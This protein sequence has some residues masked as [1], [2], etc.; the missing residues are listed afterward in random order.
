MDQNFQ[1]GMIGSRDILQIVLASSAV[2]VELLQQEPLND[3]GLPTTNKP[4]E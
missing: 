3:W 4:F 2:A 1:L